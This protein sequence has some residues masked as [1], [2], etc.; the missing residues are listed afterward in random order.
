MTW[1]IRW[2]ELSNPR[3]KSERRINNVNY[4]DD[5]TW[6]FWNNHAGENDLL[7]RVDSKTSLTKDKDVS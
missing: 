6:K 4:I 3:K 2:E 7:H 5:E 1:R